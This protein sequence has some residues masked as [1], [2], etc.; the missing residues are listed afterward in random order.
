MKRRGEDF[1]AVRREMD[2]WKATSMK[3][4]SELSQFR[5][6]WRVRVV[7]RVEAIKKRIEN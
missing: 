2:E 4:I 6:E 1:D 7:K 5:D 3:N